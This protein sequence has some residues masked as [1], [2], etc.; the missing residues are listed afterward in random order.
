[1]N[2]HPSLWPAYKQLLLRSTRPILAGPFIGECGLEVLY[3]IS[4]LDKLKS[5]GLDPKRLI[6]IS[7][8]GAGAWYG[9]P[10]AIEL[11]AMRSLQD[12]R[13]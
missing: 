13:A 6:P 12:V 10:T 11:Y 1:L 9:T 2:Y 7:R 3:W 8:G 4:F 5:Q